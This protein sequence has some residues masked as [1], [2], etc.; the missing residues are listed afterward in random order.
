GLCES[1][2]GRQSVEMAV[3]SAG[4]IRPHIRKPLDPALEKRILS[5]CPGVSVTGP[6]ADQP[7]DTVWGPIRAA[8]RS[9]AAD[10]QIRHKAAAGGTLTALATYLVASGQVDAVVHV[11]ASKENPM[12]TDMQ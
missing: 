6:G 2:A 9:W 3:T 5:V 8:W 7:A 11:R 4:F 12:L 1:M 10:P